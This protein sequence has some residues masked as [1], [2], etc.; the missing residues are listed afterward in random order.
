MSQ[1]TL[2]TAVAF[3]TPQLAALIAG[4][5]LALLL[6]TATGRGSH[7]LPN[8][9]I[10]AALATAFPFVLAWFLVAPWLGLFKADISLSWRQGWRIPLAW[11]IAAPLGAFVR[12][13]LLGRAVIPPTFVLVTIIFAT[14]FILI[15]R[16][17][18]IW[19]ASRRLRQVS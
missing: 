11:L 14:L 16:L 15:W 13:W 10:L 17:G 1:P 3:T 2:K 8:S 5:V 12:A 7:A 18:F 6:F 4:D 19:W 9:D